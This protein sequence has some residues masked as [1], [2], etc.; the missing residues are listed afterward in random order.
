MGKNND[1]YSFLSF[2]IFFEFA[3]FAFVTKGT[4]TTTVCFYVLGFNKV[5]R[6]ENIFKGGSELA[7]FE[8]YN[9][10]T[11]KQQGCKSNVNKTHKIK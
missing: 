5:R 11:P 3:R 8:T 2:D 1:L 10:G 9:N 4:V 6:K 7:D